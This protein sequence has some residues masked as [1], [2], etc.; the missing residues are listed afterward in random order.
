VYAF[1]VPA[2]GSYAVTLQAQ[3]QLDPVL[4]L[5]TECTELIIDGFTPYSG[6]YS[7]SVEPL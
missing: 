3:G 5:A 1:S 6:T 2:T 7:L 4:Y